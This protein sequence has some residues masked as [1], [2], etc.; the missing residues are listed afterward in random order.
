MGDYPN[1]RALVE[2][3]ETPSEKFYARAL[4]VALDSASGRGCD[5]HRCGVCLACSGRD[6]LAALEREAGE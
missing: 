6:R 2:V 3:A 1:L 4:L 5:S